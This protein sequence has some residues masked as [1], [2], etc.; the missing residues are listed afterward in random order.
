MKV[1]ESDTQ[2]HRKSLQ[3]NCLQK[4]SAEQKEYAGVCMSPRMTET[5]I[6][7]ANKQTERLLEEI[8]SPENL[9]QA[10]KQVKKE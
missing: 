4:V 7:S 2:K 8:L 5:D 10:Y 3:K 9:N 1:T 6:T